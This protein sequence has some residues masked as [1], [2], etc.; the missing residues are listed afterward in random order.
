[1]IFAW[2]LLCH[3]KIVLYL[4]F[5]VVCLNYESIITRRVSDLQLLSDQQHIHV[6]TESL[7]LRDLKG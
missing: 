6:C 2:K 3:R 4:S 1:M 5:V 7:Q